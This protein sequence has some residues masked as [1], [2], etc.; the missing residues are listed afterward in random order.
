MKNGIKKSLLFYLFTVLLTCISAAVLLGCGGKS[1]NGKEKPIE[2][3][4]T[5]IALTEYSI[6]IKT[7]ETYAIE[8]LNAEGEIEFSS[9]NVSVATVDGNGTVTGVADGETVIDVECGNDSLELNVTVT[10]SLAEGVD[11][12]LN[13]VSSQIYVGYE[14]TLTPKITIGRETADNSDYTFT[15]SSSAEAVATVSDTGKVR[16]VSA[17][18]ATVTASVTING[19]EYSSEVSFRVIDLDVV[20][21]SASS[22]TLS[23]TGDYSTEK[24]D[25]EYKKY[26]N[27]EFVVKD[28]VVP[29]WTSSDESV[30]TVDNGV[31]T[32][33]S[34]GTATVTVEIGGSDAV[35]EVKVYD[36]YAKI[37]D[38]AGFLD[39]D[40]HLDGYFELI[41]D[42][43]FAET[44]FLNPIGYVELPEA[45]V[46]VAD[47]GNNPDHVRTFNGHLDGNGYT[48]K[49]ITHAVGTGNERFERLIFTKIG[50]D[51]VVENIG[52]EIVN[53]N[54]TIVCGGGVAGSNLGTIRNVAVDLTI[55]GIGMAYNEWGTAGIANLNFGL[56]SSCVANIRALNGV[57]Y[58]STVCLGGIINVNK[59]AKM[60]N[61]LAVVNSAEVGV[62]SHT[63]SWGSVSGCAVVTDAS[64]ISA[65][66]NK[67]LL[68]SSIWNT[69]GEVV[70]TLKNTKET[71][72]SA[73]KIYAG[74]DG[75]NGVTLDLEGY[76]VGVR[77]DG[78]AVEYTVNGAL[79]EIAPATLAGANREK[80]TLI[81]ETDEY[82][83][84]YTLCYFNKEVI[85]PLAVV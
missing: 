66:F 68:S 74:P 62:Y 23:E 71:V 12:R 34:A 70:P 85:Q 3:E 78:K 73:E 48:V 10:E 38:A 19:E 84:L 32:G 55:S 51:G 53:G 54:S 59:G 20:N 16:G 50:A 2:N 52:F 75:A 43:D 63:G 39:I 76:V 1:D 6:S 56:V 37:Y 82:I 18:N 40:N 22:V 13:A 31:I 64:E 49:N 44:E 60:E 27:G 72:I 69:T 77:I 83:R 5:V 29:V 67:A 4:E 45:N 7:G 21:L 15:Y 11:F 33:V 65:N 61:C 28:D 57:T 80:G 25:Y 24:L 46:K 26:E 42:I 47:Y 17:G 8:V 9:R 79:L 58:G 14:L 81:V 30:V 41:N 36:Y 35:C